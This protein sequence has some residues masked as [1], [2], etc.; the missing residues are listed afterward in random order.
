MKRPITFYSTLLFLFLLQPQEVITFTFLE[1]HLCHHDEALALL[2]FK[3]VHRISTDASHDCNY[4]GQY[5]YPK[6]THWKPD[7]DCCNWDGVTCDN[8]T[9]R[10]IGLDLSCGQ[11]Q[12]VIHPNAALFDLFHLHSL[13]LAFNDFT[14]SRISQRFGSLKS[15][16]HL[17]LSN[18]NFQGEV[19]SKI[20]HLL[21]LISLDL[22][23]NLPCNS[24]DCSYLR[25]ESSNFEAMLQSLT[26]LRELS[27][28]SVN[29]SSELR[30]NFFSSLTYLI[31]WNNKQ[32][33]RL[34]LGHNLLAG[35]FLNS[36]L[37]FTH[38]GFLDLSSN[39]LSGSIPPSIFT[40]PTLS[41]LD[42]SSNHFAGE[43]PESLRNS[44]S[45]KFLDLSNN[46][47][48]CKIPSWF[49]S[50]TWDNLLY[51]NLSHN[52]LTGTIDQLQCK[53]LLYLD[54]S[55]N[56]L[57]GQM[58]SSICNSTSLFIL[59]LSYNNLVSR[60]PQCLGNFS[61]KLYVLDLGN[62]GLFGTIPITFS[63][64]SSLNILML[65]NNQLQGP[66][67]SLAHC[68]ELELLHLG[69]NKIDDRFPIW[70]ESLPNLQVLI[71][72]SN[73]FHGAIGNFQTESPFLQLRII[74]AS[75]NELTGVLPTELF[76]SLEAMRSLKDHRGEYMSETGYELDYYIHSLTLVIKGTEYS[77]ERVLID[78]TAIDFS[79]NRFEGQIPGIIGTLHSL[80]ILN[81][82]HNNLSGHIPGALG[83]L[84]RLECLD[85]SWNQLEGTIPVELL[86]LTFLEFL[87]LSENHLIG[88]IP[89][90]RHFDTFG[91]D[92]Y[93]GNLALC[94]SPLTKDCGN[95]GAPPPALPLGSEQQYDPGFFDG[96][97]WRAVVLGYGCG[98]VLGLAMGSLMFLTEKPIWFIQI[99]EESYNPRKR[100]RN[101]ICP[102]TNLRTAMQ[103]TKLNF[104]SSLTIVDLGQTQVY[105]KLPDH[106]FSLAKLQ[107]LILDGTQVTGSL[108]NFNCTASYML[109]YLDLA[110]T[111]FSGELP[112]TF[113]CLKSL[114]SMLLDG[115]QFTA[116]T[117]LFSLQLLTTLLLK[118]NLLTGQIK[119]LNGMSLTKIDLSN[120]QLYGQIPK[121]ISTLPFLGF[122][123][124]SSNNLS[125]V[126]ELSSDS[127]EYL[128][129]SNNQISWS[130][131]GNVSNSLPNLHRLELSSCE[132]KA[133]P[134]FLRS[135]KKLEVL[136]LAGNKIQGQIPSWVTSMPWDSLLYLNLS[137]N[138]LSGMDALPW[139][140]LRVLDVRFNQIQG[141][142]PLFI[143]NLK[144]LAILDL[145]RN[146]F[147]GAIPRCFGNFSSQLVVLNL[148]GN[149]LQRTINSM[150][151]AKDSR[152]R[153][154]GLNTNFLEGPLPETLANCKYLEVLD[155]GNNRL[156]D[157]FPA[158][159]QNL[160][161]LQVLV[162]SYNRFFGP[163]SIFKA[164]SPFQK[165]QIFALSCNEFSGVLSTEL[166]ESFRAMM[167]L[168]SNK[169]E[170]KYLHATGNTTNYPY[171]VNMTFKGYEIEFTKIIRTLT[172]I[173]LSSNMFHGRIP[174]VIGNLYSLKLLN[175]SNNN[176]SGHIPP[177]I[178]NLKFLETLDLSRN[179]IGGEIPMQLT[180]LTSLEVLNL[181]CN[182]L[183]GRIPQSN[184]LR[185]LGEDSYG[186]NSGLCGFPL[187]K[188][189]E[190]MH[191][192]QAP[193]DVALEQGE[194][195]SFMSGFTR[196]SVLIG[197][198]CG[199]V[200]GIASG[201]L[202]F[203]TGKPRRLVRFIEEEAYSN[204]V[205]FAWKKKLNIQINEVE[206]FGKEN[207]SFH[208][209]CLK[210]LC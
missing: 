190:E 18:S 92:S 35:K 8:I 16:T 31:Y 13:N 136:Q 20:S 101:E 90:G 48:H 59:D 83:N 157:I 98:L 71:L 15:L 54:M 109:S 181:S 146:K 150:V 24:M 198:G 93:R 204:S 45:L 199:L 162:L 177:A 102:Q 9:G 169:S 28:S 166:L 100:S 26:H 116:P 106:I 97:T 168:Q 52:F 62:N 91:N 87:N 133:F 161:E 33:T 110:Y 27:L 159:L 57:Q 74:D 148:E 164:K 153:Y 112:N 117:W 42:L 139:K 135:S 32:S 50:K 189:C 25:Y 69:N 40:I 163:I 47:I 2:Q 174:D 37:N 165:L 144:A 6:T 114:N 170:S 5:S 179:Q 123:D 208:V 142:L 207:F 68:E 209:R 55:F 173:D 84:N 38:L 29:I 131:S 81:F 1:D 11:L 67:P 105:G 76:K 128:V 206:K 175:L 86:N 108:P 10:V 95:A 111:N 34:S 119:E 126:L 115:C 171:S 205:L 156:K 138:H 203:A 44:K 99:V 125:G 193:P 160:T 178:G 180:N 61:Q 143:C 149:R 201:S 89:R 96:F 196:K 194:D 154:L 73:R 145:S 21:N 147:T 151:F 129:L 176:F 43:F 121:S 51:L 184:Q 200:L 202:M 155:V 113:G 19:A 127:L 134:E 141:Q 65:N 210:Y 130:T 77:L 7:T 53:Y 36:L 195:S 118:N 103:F 188:S 64:G 58:P 56:T 122:L 167:S 82:S 12:G 66:L 183:I 17:N 158:W 60:I 124:L 39:Q 70:L 140:N 75:C 78:R 152:L 4:F 23:F 49:M 46:R 120:N 79:S 72:K 63:Q 22:S 14:G 41:Y 88:P 137:Y 85:L 192:P 107:Q 94:G 132:M 30:V 104:S 182:H 185:T 80:L 187:T 3:E 172:T 191:V 197:Y 186:G